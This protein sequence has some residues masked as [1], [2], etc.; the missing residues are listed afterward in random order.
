MTIDDGSFEDTT[1]EF[2]NFYRIGQCMLNS[3]EMH[4]PVNEL[5][6]RKYAIFSCLLGYFISGQLVPNEQSVNQPS[7]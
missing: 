6:E 4:N 7:L 2:L 3:G 5:D 1:E